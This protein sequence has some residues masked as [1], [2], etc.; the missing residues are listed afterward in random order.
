VVGKTLTLNGDL[1]TIVG[2]IPAGFHYQ[3]GNF[4][5][6]EVYTPIGQWSDPTFRDRRVSMGTD[7]VA[8]LAPGVTLA[9]AKAQMT[10]IAAHL[11]EQYPHADSGTGITL[12]PLKQDIVAGIRPFLLVL[13]AA[14]GFVLLIA[15]A[16][17]ANLLL[18]RSFGR[19][20]EFAIRAA[21]GASRGS[22]IRQLLTESLVLALAGGLLGLGLADWGTRAALGVLPAALP[23]SG[24]IRIDARVLFFTLLVSVLAGI[25]FGLAPALKVSRLGLHDALKEGGRGSSGTRHKTQRILVVVE[26][27]LAVVLLVG[28]GLMIRSLA[29]IWS[30]N[31]GFDP[32][33]VL[34]FDLSSPRP[35]GASP[36]GIRAAFRRIRRQVAAVPGVEA[37]S[38]MGGS[39]PMSGESDMRFWVAGDPRP[40]SD[41]NLKTALFYAVQPE[42][43]Q[44][45]R[46]P[47]ERGRLFTNR[48]GARSLP[49]VVIDERFARLYF[50]D[51]DPIGRLINVDVLGRSLEIV[52][53]VGHVKQW[54]LDSTGRSRIQAQM[55]LP[56]SQIPNQFLPLISRGTTIVARTRAAPLAQVPAVRQAI[57][58]LNGELVMYSPESMDGII[59]DSLAGRRFSMILLAVFAGLALVLACVGIYG[60]VSYLA[61]QRL[62]EMG[63]RMALGAGRGDVLRLV[64]GE[65]ARM[66]VAGI[67]FGLVAALGLTRLISRMIFGVSAHD[68]VT[69]LAVCGLLLLVA[70]AASSVP[71][72]RV[73]RVD[74]L[75]ALRHE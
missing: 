20:R 71:A 75:K 59:S 43:F 46:I 61:G 60:V 26:M 15:C 40:A 41:A 50:G 19:V 69:L 74:P 29:K 68:P 51:R 14:V 66:A 12:I 9:Q 65:S 45:L 11:A 52:G 5:D 42:Y 56:L 48:D 63:I 10:A 53:V 73:M 55:Y 35:L 18:A 31:P 25:L 22:L 28:A 32:S 72:R 13:V 44:C 47:L 67:G 3:S 23:R 30:V 1:Y 39:L 36:D 37:A 4:H 33:Q 70:L 54:G 38:L 49:V 7:A 16:N 34:T 8:R 24:D 57:E 6:S 64:L 21:L 27:A 58:R 2:V 62:H 17:I